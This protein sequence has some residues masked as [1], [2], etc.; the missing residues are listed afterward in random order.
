[1]NQF[2]I[3]SVVGFIIFVSYK[4][5][6]NHMY[7]MLS[8]FAVVYLFWGDDVKKQFLS[9]TKDLEYFIQSDTQLMS[10]IKNISFLQVKDKWAY[11]KTIDDLHRFLEH[12]ISFFRNGVLNNQDFQTFIDIRRNIL[13][14]LSLLVVSDIEIPSSYID[15]IADCTWKYIYAISTKYDISINQPL[16]FNTF[17]GQDLY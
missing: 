3:L 15:Q 12:Y 4:L 5:F 7:W 10:F 17:H 9:D 16:A 8:I 2:F 6:G 1:M 13:N 11:K 14:D